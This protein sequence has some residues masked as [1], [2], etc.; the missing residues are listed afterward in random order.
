MIFKN[1]PLTFGNSL[2]SLPMS[3][4]ESKGPEDK[5]IQRLQVEIVEIELVNKIPDINE[6]GSA[7]TKQIY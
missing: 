1:D 4:F 5:L 3:S 2:I 7:L 6:L